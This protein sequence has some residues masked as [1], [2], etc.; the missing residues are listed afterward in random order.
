MKVAIIQALCLLGLFVFYRAFGLPFCMSAYL[1]CC[2]FPEL[3]PP[4]SAIQILLKV[5]LQKVRFKEI[6]ALKKG[7]PYIYGS[8]YLKFGLQFQQEYQEA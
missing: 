4:I 5:Q 8:K 3:T 7:V 6:F 2:V 1:H